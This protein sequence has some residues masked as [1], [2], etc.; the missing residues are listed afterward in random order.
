MLPPVAVYKNLQVHFLQNLFQSARQSKKSWLFENPHNLATYEQIFSVKTVTF[1]VYTI[2]NL[3]RHT[4][5]TQLR[6][7]P[8]THK[9]RDADSIANSALEDGDHQ[10]TTPTATLRRVLRRAG[11]PKLRTSL[12][13]KEQFKGASREITAKLM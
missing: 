5:Y 10:P 6:V 8:K 4:F 1:R 13:Y 3:F 11:S 12:F 7:Y 9:L 2:K